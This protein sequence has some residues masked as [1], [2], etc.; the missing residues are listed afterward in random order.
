MIDDLLA[1]LVKLVV[2]ALIAAAAI[3]VMWIVHT[4][5]PW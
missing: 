5:V 1:E 3:G 4:A 2:G